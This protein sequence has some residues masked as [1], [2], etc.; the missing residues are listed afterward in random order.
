MNNN[1]TYSNELP[2]WLEFFENNLTFHGT[3]TEFDINYTISLQA[4]DGYLN[5]SDNFYIDLS[6]E[7]IQYLTNDESNKFQNQFETYQNENSI[8]VGRNFSF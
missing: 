8:K 7:P 4:S 1:L 5:I 3:P 6:I 2:F